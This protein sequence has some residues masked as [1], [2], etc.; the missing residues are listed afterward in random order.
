MKEIKL[1][2]LNIAKCLIMEQPFQLSIKKCL[3]HKSSFI[4]VLY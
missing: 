1:M 3:S 2:D 4:H